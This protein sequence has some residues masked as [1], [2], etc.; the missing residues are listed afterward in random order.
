MR[1]SFWIEDRSP[2][3]YFELIKEEYPEAAFW[4]VF[5][6]YNPIPIA[7]ADRSIDWLN[8]Q[9]ELL[10]TVVNTYFTDSIMG[11]DEIELFI[12][13]LTE[14]SYPKEEQYFEDIDVKYLSLAKEI[15]KT[16]LA[17]LRLNDATFNNF[18]CQLHI[19]LEKH[20]REHIIALGKNEM[21][22]RLSSLPHYSEEKKQEIIKNYLK[23]TEGYYDDEFYEN[24]VAED[25]FEEREA[26][27]YPQIDLAFSDTFY[28]DNDAGN[29]PY[30]K[31]ERI[32]NEKYEN[33]KAEITE[34]L[35]QPPNTDLQPKFFGHLSDSQWDTYFTFAE[36]HPQA[37]EF[38]EQFAVWSNINKVL[39]LTMIKED[40]ETP[41]EIKLGGM[42]LEDYKTLVAGYNAIFS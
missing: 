14:F 31:Q 35:Q 20:N 19:V 4:D 3:Q 30:K 15:Y 5:T 21:I 34:L 26:I 18:M 38:N 32:A 11:R 9:K 23:M 24:D 13:T 27:I 12:N 37:Y 7:P 16:C 29:I 36:A 1:K 17:P 39:Y 28:D 40:K 22:K 2:K 8:K 6:T 41:Y 42:P 33:F 10:N 25:D